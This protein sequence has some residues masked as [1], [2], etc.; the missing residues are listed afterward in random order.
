MDRMIKTV[1]AG[2][3]RLLNYSIEVMFSVAER[4]ESASAALE[5]LYGESMESFEAVRFLAV[6][7]ANDGELCRREAGYDPEPMLTVEDVSPRMSP[8]EYIKL[9]EAVAAAIY[10]GYRRDVSGGE[11]AEQDM[12]LAELEAKKATTGE[13]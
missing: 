4:Y 12:G 10:A 9:R 3:E 1:I 6:M 2:H 13:N 8:A 7:M 5:K 11:D